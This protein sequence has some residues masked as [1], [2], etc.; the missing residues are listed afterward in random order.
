[1]KR[2]GHLYEKLISDENLD[3]A[4]T[5]VNKSHRRENGRINI[6]TVLV[7]YNRE[8]CIK[9]LRDTI[10][11]GFVPSAARKNKV[12]DKGA[13]KERVIY[14]PCQWPDQYIHHA[15]IQVLKPI[16]MKGMDPYC[17][18][19]IEGRGIEYGRKAIEGWV[20]KEVYI[21]KLNKYVR[22]RSTDYVLYCDI[23]HFYDSLPPKVVVDRFSRLI[24]DK[25]VLDLIVRITRNGVRIGYFTSQ[26]FANTVLQP[27]DRLIRS[28]KDSRGNNVCKRYLRYM[29]DMNIFGSNKRELHKLRE[30]IE[31][32][33]N[34]HGLELK[35]NY[36]VRSLKND[37]VDALGYRFGRNYTIP[38]KRNVLNLKRTSSN[39]RKTR[40]R[41]RTVSYR[42]AAG[43]ISRYGILKHCNNYNLYHLITNGEPFLGNMKKIAKSNRMYKD[44]KHVSTDAE[45]V[46]DSLDLLRSL[47]SVN[48]VLKKKLNQLFSNSSVKSSNLKRKYNSLIRLLVIELSKA[49]EDADSELISSSVP[50]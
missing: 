49:T 38:R 10:E 40:K 14:E 24:K 6:L 21:K 8:N 47:T 32:W 12:F 42:K 20:R 4:I 23:H 50:T 41:G 19:S 16:C 27:L 35:G 34:D 37:P 31:K 28:Y 9:L 22:D 13:N 5:N 33:L 36:Q 39:I 29:D 18:G 25:K 15:L 45:I 3:E 30:V 2:V 43:A 48:P 17:C 11:S 44:Y 1:M 7:E 46:S 26:W